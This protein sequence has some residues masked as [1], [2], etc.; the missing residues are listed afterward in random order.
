MDVW[1]SDFM[2]ITNNPF[3]LIMLSFVCS[4]T[5]Q[6]SYLLCTQSAYLQV[7]IY[8]YLDEVNVEV[9]FKKL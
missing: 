5:L 7:N 1:I 2:A 8:E 3:H 6:T 9:M 4:Y